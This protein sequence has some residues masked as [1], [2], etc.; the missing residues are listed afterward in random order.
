MTMAVAVP[1][2]VVA[3]LMTVMGVLMLASVYVR[4]TV[5]AAVMEAA[6]A[7]DDAGTAMMT[8]A[9]PPGVPGGCVT[10]LVPVMPVLVTVIVV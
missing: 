4:V 3:G 7:P 8:V 2:C 6:G 10:V 5:V 1:C 9:V